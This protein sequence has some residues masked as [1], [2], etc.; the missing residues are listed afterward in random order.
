VGTA[1]D[2][3]LGYGQ[4]VG[5]LRRLCAERATGS[6][7]ITTSDNHAARF[8]LANGAIIA[9]WF[10]QQTGADALASIQRVTGG[11]LR[12][13]DEVLAHE[14]QPAVP[15]TS[16]ILA[17]LDGAGSGN[18]A[19]PVQTK[20]SDL[21]AIPPQ[22]RSIIESELAEYL[23]PMASVIVTEQVAVASSVNDLIERLASELGDAGKASRLKERL[24]ERLPAKK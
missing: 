22:S 12:Y 14:P 19:A 7:F 24:R 18:G 20:V 4:L 1:P 5:E 2:S 23:G 21:G 10:R 15:S 8:A 6:V 3:V 11:K 17:M 13:S 16:E 9:V